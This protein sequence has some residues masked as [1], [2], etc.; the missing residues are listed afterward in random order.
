MIDPIL[1]WWL[2]SLELTE[3]DKDILWNL[4]REEDPNIKGDFED[5]T[6]RFFAGLPFFNLKDYK[7]GFDTCATNIIDNLFK[8]YDAVVLPVGSGPAN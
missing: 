7:L 2:D 3:Q 4:Q 6:N 8:D 5:I 1:Q